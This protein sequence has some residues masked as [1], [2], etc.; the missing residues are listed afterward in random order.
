M[1]LLPLSILPQLTDLTLGVIVIKVLDQDLL[2]G[3]LSLDGVQILDLLYHMLVLECLHVLQLRF[4]AIY[5]AIEDAVIEVLGVQL[6]V[7]I[8]DLDGLICTKDI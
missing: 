2:P 6:P 4:I 1:N 3:S 7:K 8:H 5:D